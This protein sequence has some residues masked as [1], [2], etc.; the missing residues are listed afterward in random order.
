MIL[1]I[2]VVATLPRPGRATTLTADQAVDT[3]RVA[4][5]L[6]N[7][8]DPSIVFGNN[9][10]FA[11]WRDATAD[12][13]HGAIRGARFN[14]D[15]SIVDDP[16]LVILNE[17]GDPFRPSIAWDGS[18]FLIAW[19]DSLH[20]YARYFDPATN[21]LST[22]FNLASGTSVT[23]EELAVAGGGG[24]SFAI[25]TD[26]NIGFPSLIF[27]AL[28]DSTGNFVVKDSSLNPKDILVSQN[29]AAGGFAG[30]LAH[31][32]AIAFSA[33]SAS[34]NFLAAWDE[35][36]SA[37]RHALRGALIN[38]SGIPSAVPTCPG[39][40]S[41]HPYCP[42]FNTFD[43]VNGNLYIAHNVTIS[44][45][46]TN[47]F[48]AWEDYRNGTHDTG[49][50]LLPNE[51]TIYGRLVD[52]TGTPLPAPSGLCPDG[53]TV[54]ATTVDCGGLACS[55]PYTGKAPPCYGDHLVAK[56]AN[57]MFG[58]P[59]SAYL[60]PQTT[61]VGTQFLVAWEW[62]DT[63]IPHLF[64]D[65]ISSTGAQL[66]GNGLQIS[67]A[68]R[69]DLPDGSR[70]SL[71]ASD[72]TKALLAFT[73]TQNG[74]TGDDTY[75]APV[76][77]TQPLTS[78]SPIL[79][80]RGRT[81]QFERSVASNGSE[82]LIVWEDDRNSSVSGLD[83]YGMRVNSSGAKIDAAPFVICDAPGDQFL[84]AAAAAKGGDFLVAW[85]DARPGA[86]P[87]GATSIWAGRVDAGG[88]RKDGNGVSLRTN[89]L[90][91]AR[92][93]PAVAASNNGWL[94]AWEDWNN[95]QLG[96]QRPEVWSTTVS[97][98]MVVGTEQ[99]I[100]VPGNM[101]AG[102]ACAPAAVWNGM[103]FFVAYEQ[104]CTQNQ[105]TAS[106]PAT[107]ALQGSVI[108]RW[109][110]ADGTVGQV[111]VVVATSV[112]D[113][114]TRPQLVAEDNTD[115]IAVWGAAS[116]RSTRIDAALIADNATMPKTTVTIA[117][118]AG[119]RQSPSVAF[120]SSSI[121]NGDVF[122]TWIDD[123]PLGVRAQRADGQLNLIG[124]PMTLAGTQ[125][126]K[127]DSY[128]MGLW[129]PSEFSGFDVASNPRATP[130]AA[131][132]ALSSGEALAAYDLLVPFGGSSYSE[133]HFRVL[134]LG[135]TGATCTESSGC[136]DGICTHGICCN[137]SCDGICQSCGVNGCVE[138]P[139]SDDRCSSSP[140]SCAS[141]STTCRTYSDLPANRC[142]LFGQCAEGSTIADCTS[143]S[144]AP[145]GTACSSPSLACGNVG[146]C[147]AGRC[148]CT[149]DKDLT[150]TPR[151][152]AATSG[153]SALPTR[154]GSSGSPLLLLMTLVAL[155]LA[156]SRRRS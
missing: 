59:Q 31:A 91:N 58:G 130:P 46:G 6:N 138:T 84:P 71:I 60:A 139:A 121:G 52:L 29:G 142:A 38:T 99:Q 136:L 35:N 131:T 135:T 10:Y 37:P 49:F 149:N 126:F 105:L 146:T 93:A 48:L 79:L 36:D 3:L 55:C 50:G 64:G 110:A 34:P 51:P 67:T 114:D 103:R 89:G 112:V 127:V 53:T 101:P 77:P 117:S 32:P 41:S 108:G 118:N 57:P 129:A 78:T 144:D 125:P 85:S 113:S 153:C 27:G 66:D 124:N 143:Y 13:S 132:V 76:D 88:T 147:S 145:D 68:P 1:A 106:P 47:Y 21:S 22:K 141:L 28:L 40:V 81:Y 80:S 111:D 154:N 56:P 44:S 4:P 120:A 16:P 18:R 54:C 123:N 23:Q 119:T 11:V 83:I 95:V 148:V 90:V 140:V 94:V 107:Q 73:Q 134:G 25:W 26:N 39:T 62:S 2:A 9:Q 155:G 74:V 72:G 109:V 14:P 8:A 96:D 19:E 12:N 137:T 97:S 82:F 65:R 75:L 63:Y 86:S 5:A 151:V 87:T 7:Q 104:P 122:I 92:L 156:R 24:F 98:S 69:S 115:V 150:S 42:A 128:P 30:E 102:I 133:A 116:T 100:T 45:N 61:A 15:F 70:R 17:G 20:A 152:A 43:T 33:S